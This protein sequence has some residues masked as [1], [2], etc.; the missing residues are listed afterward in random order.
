VRAE[1]LAIPFVRGGAFRA[2]G[3]PHFVSGVMG[4]ALSEPVRQAAGRGFVVLDREHA[5]GF[6]NFV[7]AYLLIARVGHFDPHARIRSSPSARV[8]CSWA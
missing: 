7:V 2:N 4:R 5:V 8:F 3:V 1:P 6:G